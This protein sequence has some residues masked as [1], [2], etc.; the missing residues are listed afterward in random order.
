MVLKL[1]MRNVIKRKNGYFFRIVIPEDLRVHF[2]GLREK[3]VTL[4]TCAP[5]DANA[6]AEPLRREW[7]AKFTALRSGQ[8]LLIPHG[9][10]V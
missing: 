2:D 10:L 5:L 7:K 3:Q 8:S 6:K 1:V 9:C 4:G